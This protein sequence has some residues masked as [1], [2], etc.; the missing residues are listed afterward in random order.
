LTLALSTK[1][2]VR[3]GGGGADSSLWFAEVVAIAGEGEV[4]V[5]PAAQAVAIA[6]EGA[7]GGGGG[8]C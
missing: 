3:I 6:G 1:H 5:A 8:E 7:L 4:G 2:H